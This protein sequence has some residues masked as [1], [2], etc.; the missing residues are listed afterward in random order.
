MAVSVPRGILLDLEHVLGGHA[1]HAELTLEGPTTISGCRYTHGWAPDRHLYFVIE[2][3]QPVL[4][5]AELMVDGKPTTAA[6][7]TIAGTAVKA[8]FTFG[9]G[10]EQS[11]AA[12]ARGHFRHRH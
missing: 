11:T 4:G 10:D 3:S 2:F 1:Y 9:S 5:S 6:P 8:R 7:N 12:G